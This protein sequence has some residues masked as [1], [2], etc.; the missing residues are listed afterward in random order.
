[1]KRWIPWAT[2]LLVIALVAA[3]LMRTLSARQARAQALAASTSTQA[4]GWLELAQTD[5]VRAHPRDM[6]QGMAI[7][8]ALR[9]VNS[10][11]IKARV[12]GELQDLTV[13]EGDSVQAGQVIARIDDSE[14]QSRLRQA[15]QQAE[16]A[17]AQMA[18]AQRQF[19]N[20]LALVAQ[21]F[22]SKT[23]LDT[24]LANL[25]AAR[26]THQAALAGA[27]VAAR[28]VQDTVLRSPIAGQVS[29]RLAQPGERV[30]IDT[31]I[32][33]VLDL[34]RLELEASLGAQDSL[35]VRV[36]Q[37][38]TLR[39]E[40]SPQP[41]TATVARINPSAQAGS[42]GVLVYLT[43]NN[44]PAGG[45]PALPLRQ[46]LFAQ[47]VLGTAQTRQLAVPLDSLR[48]DRPAPYVQAI[49]D[50]RVVHLPVEPG[51]R[52]TAD[53]EALVAVQGL[54]DGTLVVRGNIGILREGTA[55]RFTSIGAAGTATAPGSAVKPAP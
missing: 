45:G 6:A 25:N 53:G 20:N 30:G 27:E 15:R 44:P 23:A 54:A 43:I 22:I 12:P 9:A 16:S 42:R 24:S 5:V 40:G 36:G 50:S 29:Q 14:V 21:G 7:S 28:S 2:A 19:D 31:R 49:Q 10:A 47:G 32:V 11:L 35:Q 38:A 55:V 52:G 18:V 48:T 34:S 51:Q 8:G 33:E 3:G 26:A 41:V 13:R 4:P 17:R 39:I 1:M 46:G 37:Q